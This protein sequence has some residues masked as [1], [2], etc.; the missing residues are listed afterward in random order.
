MRK[1]GA[2]NWILLLLCLMYMILYVDRV[3]IST[4]ASRCPGSS[5]FGACYL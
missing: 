1:F 5:C 3:N 2:S 4:A